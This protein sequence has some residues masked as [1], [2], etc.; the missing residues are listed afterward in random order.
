MWSG[1][2]RA[3]GKCENAPAT[4]GAFGTVCWKLEPATGPQLNGPLSPTDCVPPPAMAER[5]SVS[6]CTFLIR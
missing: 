6:D 1:P 2:R 4:T 5:M 3:I